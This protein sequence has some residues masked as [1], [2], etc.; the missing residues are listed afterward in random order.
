MFKKRWRTLEVDYK[1]QWASWCN[2]SFHISDRGEFHFGL[3]QL[4][5]MKNIHKPF[6]GR[7]QSWEMEEFTI[8]LTRWQDWW[9]EGKKTLKYGLAHWAIYGFDTGFVLANVPFVPVNFF[10]CLFLCCTDSQLPVS[11]CTQHALTYSW[12]TK[13]ALNWTSPPPTSPPLVIQR[14]S[15]VMRPSVIRSW[16]YHFYH[17]QQPNM[18]PALAWGEDM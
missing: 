11:W 2:G 12:Q 9:L 15:L 3:L 10:P 8:R 7:E 18:R 5:A 13:A 16:K 17:I 1:R 14:K 6:P 4:G